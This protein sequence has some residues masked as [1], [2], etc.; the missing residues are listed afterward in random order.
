VGKNALQ[1]DFD[2]MQERATILHRLLEEARIL[3]S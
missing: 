3:A 1:S 2:R